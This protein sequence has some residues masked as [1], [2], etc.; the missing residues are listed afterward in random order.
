[1]KPYEL[2]PTKD[3][4]IQTFKNDT[5]GRNRDILRFIT[6]LDS[7]NDSCAIALDGNWGSGKTFFVKQTKMVLDAHNCHVNRMDEEDTDAIIKECERYFKNVSLEI[8]PQVC[9]YYDAWENDNDDDPILSLV[10][11]I[12]NSVSHE[13]SFQD[14]SALNI[15]ASVLETV[16]GR[17]WKQIVESLKGN[18]PLE[19]LQ[20]EKGLEQLVHEFLESLLIERG[21]RLIVF[22]DELD[23]CKP[24]FAV[25]LLERIKHYFSHKNITFV[26]SVNLKE[27]QHTIRNHYGE[28]FDGFRY[29]DRFFDLRMSLPQ[30]DLRRFYESIGFDNGHYTYEMVCDAVIKFYRFE[31]REI[32]KYVQLSKIAAYEPT[33]SDTHNFSFPEGIALQFCLLYFVPI[34]IGLKILNLEKYTDFIEGKDFSPLIE[35]ANYFSSRM[36]EGLL[37]IDETYDKNNTKMTVVTVEEKLKAVYEALFV[38][39]YRVNAVGTGIGKMMFDAGIKDILL[40]TVGLLSDYTE[41]DMD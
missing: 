33:H 34:M 3:N 7:I 26:F 32:A 38:K 20:E 1:M 13:F 39:S 29:L 35:I 8:Q 11:T 16:T 37:K 21:N 6:I 40:R 25:C 10:Y 24:S 4:L 23:R 2:K 5:I 30:P 14:R 15:G 28:D 19:A 9:V 27:L 18:N 31:L 22:V 12:L 36:F 41:M 17:N